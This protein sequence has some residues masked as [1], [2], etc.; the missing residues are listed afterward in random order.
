[1][2]AVVILNKKLVNGLNLLPGI[3]PD[4]KHYRGNRACM[5]QIVYFSLGL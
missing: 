1:M 5:Q 2:I 4:N 3:I